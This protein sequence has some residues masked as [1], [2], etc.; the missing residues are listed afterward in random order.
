VLPVEFA[1]LFT[2]LLTVVAASFV[3][4][5]TV[6]AAPPIEVVAFALALPETPA[7]PEEILAVGVTVA[8]AL[9]FPPEFVVLTEPVKFLA[10]IFD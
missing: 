2:V 9:V 5:T 4:L 7:V 6:P 8:L 3:A 10:S 1:T